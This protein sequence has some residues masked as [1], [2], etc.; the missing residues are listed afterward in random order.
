[1]QVWFVK[2]INVQKITYFWII[3]TNYVYYCII[4]GNIINDVIHNIRINYI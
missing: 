1:M 3:I 2:C 4:A